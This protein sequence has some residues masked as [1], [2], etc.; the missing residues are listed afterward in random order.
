MS[1][2]PFVAINVLN[3]PKERA[4]VLE[5][6]FANRAGQVD[7]M[8]GFR[9]FELLRP[10]SGQ[11]GY[12]VYTRWDSKEHFDAWVASM[13]F[14]QGHAQQAQGAPAATDSQVWTFEA[15]QMKDAAAEGD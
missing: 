13:E 9:H 3:V 2:T 12:L 7:S 8:D 1:E 15:I 14:T 6:R 5:E 11:E 4:A 10:V